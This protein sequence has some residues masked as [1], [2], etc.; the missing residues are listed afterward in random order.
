MKLKNQV[1]MKALAQMANW[2]IDEAYWAMQNRKNSSKNITYEKNAHSMRARYNFL[3]RLN[4]QEFIQSGLN[5]IDN[6]TTN[7]DETKF[8]NYAIKE[9]KTIPN[10]LL[11]IPFK[12]VISPFNNGKYGKLGEL[13]GNNILVK[14]IV[15]FLNKEGESPHKEISKINNF[16]TK[17]I[18]S[19]SYHAFRYKHSLKVMNMTPV[20]ESFGEGTYAFTNIAMVNEADTLDYVFTQTNW[21]E[22]LQKCF[23]KQLSDIS[24]AIERHSKYQHP[25]R[26]L[27]YDFLNFT[28]KWSDISYKQLLHEASLVPRFLGLSK[29]F[30]SIDD[31][32]YNKNVLSLSTHVISNI[33]K[34]N[35][36]KKKIEQLYRY[37]IRC[38]HD[39][40]LLHPKYRFFKKKIKDKDG[41]SKNI[42][43]VKMKIFEQVSEEK[44]EKIIEEKPSNILHPILAKV[45]EHAKS[46]GS[47]SYEFI[48][49]SIKGHGVSEEELEELLTL[50][51]KEKIILY[52]NIE[53]ADDL[54]KNIWTYA[55]LIMSKKNNKSVTTKELID[56]LPEYID[57]PED[58]TKSLESRIDNKFSQLVRNLKSHRTNKTNF[59]YLGYVESIDKGFKITKKGLNFVKD[60]FEKE[61]EP[62]IF[63]RA[64]KVLSQKQIYSL[65]YGEVSES[66]TLDQESFK[67]VK[68]G[69]LCEGIFGPVNNYECSCGKYKGQKHRGL[70]CEKCGVE[71][72]SSENRLMRLGHIE[73]LQEVYDIRYL[74]VMLIYL[75][76]VIQD[77]RVG[78]MSDKVQASISY[79]ELIDLL[80]CNKYI[81]LWTK[82]YSEAEKKFK[83]FEILSEEKYYNI[84][85]TENIFSKIQIAQGVKAFKGIYEHFTD[86]IIDDII[87]KFNNE[88]L[89]FSNE[90]YDQI[91]QVLNYYNTEK[92][93]SHFIKYIPVIPQNHKFI[94]RHFPAFFKEDLIPYYQKI[95]ET[96]NRVRHL[97]NISAYQEEINEKVLNLQEDVDSFLETDYFGE[98]F[99]CLDSN[100]AEL[101]SNND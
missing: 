12:Y 74:N 1:S 32:A 65:S 15:L 28:Y 62:E 48:T 64:C 97:Y 86:D 19:I 52:G 70:V 63:L 39:L 92:F 31:E 34:R 53:K 84:V 94:K 95:I 37:D 87:D 43:Q 45:L 7:V 81:V 38:I 20:R 27:S 66:K 88:T 77:Y 78:S 18:A 72:V 73:L 6:N 54:K 4:F 47:C 85:K 76:F 71:V 23:P 98:V 17:A 14:D 55:L 89:S 99:E 42:L 5:G 22:I 96:N 68:G 24:S 67:P 9:F 29:D 83:L 60:Y 51:K 90:N 21:L 82:P 13:L 46:R 75:N 30:T 93:K 100:F 101:T 40:L 59:I 50:F 49:N 35:N 26:K 16:K 41:N 10:F 44:N 69:L 56:K 11:N 3:P 25:I 61:E 57:I 80:Y 36:V 2:G 33:T 8:I 79:E 58:A 91:Y